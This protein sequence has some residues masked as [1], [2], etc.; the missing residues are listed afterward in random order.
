MPPPP[1]T[2]PPEESLHARR[3]LNPPKQ[4]PPPP[5]TPPPEESLHARRPLNP[6]KTGPSLTQSTALPPK[7]QLPAPT[8]APAIL[9]IK[10]GGEQAIQ[11]PNAAD[12]IQKQKMD[13]QARMER[14]RELL[15]AARPDKPSVGPLTDSPPLPQAAQHS[16]DPKDSIRRENTFMK[17]RMSI[18]RKAGTVKQS[19]GPALPSL[20]LASSLN[21]PKQSPPPP[22]TPPPEESLHARRPRQPL[23]DEDATELATGPTSKSAW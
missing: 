19:A 10:S 9:Q 3:P 5:S 11:R 16:I 22:S 6:P 21:P 4:I 2:P 7:L 14:Q 23:N 17:Q 13:M 1:S 15:A 12:K 20:A 8:R 18:A